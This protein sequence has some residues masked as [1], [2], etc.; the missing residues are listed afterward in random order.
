M[1]SETIFL[2]LSSMP[3]RSSQT[4]T[5]KNLLKMVAALIGSNV[6]ALFVG[7][8][9]EYLALLG[10]ISVAYA[11]IV[12]LFAWIIL[13]LGIFSS[14]WIWSTT[15]VQRIWGAVASILVGLILFGFHLFIIQTCKLP[16]PPPVPS[17]PSPPITQTSVDSQCANVVSEGNVEINCD[18]E[19]KSEKDRHPHH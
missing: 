2:K 15:R 17:A 8:I 14:E 16:A 19:D 7:A 10:V 12:L 3:K 1:G 6:F 18:T 11:W 13:T 5:D 4:Q 9:Y